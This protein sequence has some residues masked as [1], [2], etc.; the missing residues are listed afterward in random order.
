MKLSEAVQ[1]IIRLGEASRTYWDREL[2]KHHARYPIIQPGEVSPPPPPEDAK[3]EA[4][5]NSLSEDQVY[6]LI[7]LNYVGPGG[8]R[9]DDLPSTYQT[10]KEIFPSK[11]LAIAQMVETAM[12]LA[13][14]LMDA[15]EALQKRHIDVDNLKF[16]SPLAV[17]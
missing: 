10:M 11:E 5:L 7:L 9:A 16:E 1:E 15:M 12:N 8:F 6:I 2:R 3:I 13:D 14:N 17:S 4:L